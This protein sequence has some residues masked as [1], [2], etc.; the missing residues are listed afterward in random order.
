VFGF[1][2][3]LRMAPWVISSESST[4]VS[5]VFSGDIPAPET[6]GTVERRVF[7]RTMAKTGR[8]GRTGGFPERNGIPIFIR[9]RG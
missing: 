3:L 9:S 1:H 5:T 2:F 4:G 6:P 8:S 7:P